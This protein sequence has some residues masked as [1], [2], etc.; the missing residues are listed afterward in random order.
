QPGD[1]IGLLSLNSIEFVE[2]LFAIV[3]AGCVAV[4]LNPRHKA[5]EL[6][7]I[8]DHARLKS[9]FVSSSNQNYVDFS[10]LVREALPSLDNAQDIFQLSLPEAP[11]LNTAVLLDGASGNN[12]LSKNDF[13]SIRGKVSSQRIEND[14]R[15]V[16]VRDIAMILYTSGTTANPK[17]CLL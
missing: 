12:F 11:Q 5:S 2:A 4:P 17:G 16:R 8:I 3:L 6:G 15:R 1:H 13:D 9:L 7:Y 14:R 10:T